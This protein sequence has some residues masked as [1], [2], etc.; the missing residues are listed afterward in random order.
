MEHLSASE[1]SRCTS[2]LFSRP[3]RFCSYLGDALIHFSF[4]LLLHCSDMLAP[5]ELLGPLANYVFLRYIGGDR[6]NEADQE[7]R[8][9]RQDPVKKGHLEKYQEEKNKFWPGVNELKNGWTWVVV[10]AG[11]LGVAVEKGFRAWHHA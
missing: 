5:L 11:A 3:N 9:A 4:P 2:A 7:E 8:Y 10:G 1:V 6:E